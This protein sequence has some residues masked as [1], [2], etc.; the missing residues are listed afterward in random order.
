MRLLHAR[1]RHERPRLPAAEAGRL[2]AGDRGHFRRQSLSLH[3]LSADPAR[4]ADAGPR[5]RRRQG[6]DAEMPDRSV[7]PDQV[8][9]ANWL[10][11]TW[12]RCLRPASRSAPSLHRQRLRMV[13]ARHAW[14][15]P[16]PQETVRR[17]G[18]S[19]AGQARLRQHRLGGLSEGETPVSDRHLRHC[20]TGTDRR[21]GSGH[22]RRRRRADPATD[23][24]RDRRDRPAAGRTDDRAA[25]P[26]AARHLHCRLSGALR[27]QRGRQ[28]LHDPRPRPSRRRRSPPTC[29]PSWPPSAPRSPSA[30]KSTKAAAGASR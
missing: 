28:Y 19:R 30:R 29:S 18:G 22:P 25:G 5:L 7:V 14:R 8:P 4:R 10:G 16:A 9:E 24:C 2:A 21:T 12:T 1:V 26:E 15:G 27:G 11:S 23:R 17:P 13:S 6:R 20:G 3:G